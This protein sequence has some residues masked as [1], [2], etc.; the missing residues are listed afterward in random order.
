[1]PAFGKSLLRLIL[2]NSKM[3]KEQTLKIKGKT[4]EDCIH[5]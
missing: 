2:K 5:K 1:M 4:E 3:E